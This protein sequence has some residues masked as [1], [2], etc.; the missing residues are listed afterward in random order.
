MCTLWRV[1]GAEVVVENRGIEGGKG[2]GSEDSSEWW[3]SPSVALPCWDACPRESVFSCLVPWLPSA[4]S[5]PA[6]RRRV[7]AEV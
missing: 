6:A 2:W 7:T 4:Y 3:I 5:K 1:Y